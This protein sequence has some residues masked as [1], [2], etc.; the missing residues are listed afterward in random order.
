MINMKKNTRLERMRI[1]REKGKKWCYNAKQDSNCEYSNSV[2]F[3][4][5]YVAM[6]DDFDEDE[7][8]FW[9]PMWTKMIS[10]L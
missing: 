5:V 9:F 10:G 8:T 4:V 3:E 7:T 2:E 1:T 6:K